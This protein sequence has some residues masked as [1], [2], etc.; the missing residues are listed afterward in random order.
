MLEIIKIQ[1]QN[2][3]QGETKLILKGLE[4]TELV[5]KVVPKSTKPDKQ[6][7]QSTEKQLNEPLFQ[8]Y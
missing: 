3:G 5:S 8:I 1:Q 4:G 2:L 6:V 7:L